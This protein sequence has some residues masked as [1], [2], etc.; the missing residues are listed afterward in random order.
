MGDM[1]L[2]DLT[3]STPT[4]FIKE[5]EMPLP[6]AAPLLTLPALQ[7]PTP[8]PAGGKAPPQRKSA[9]RG[10]PSVAAGTA[11][12]A[13]PYTPSTRSAAKAPSGPAAA[14]IA[15]VG[16]AATSATASA[17][18]PAPVVVNARALPDGGYSLQP[19]TGMAGQSPLPR[20]PAPHLDDSRASQAWQP[21]PQLQVLG[22]PSAGIG[23]DS[24]SQV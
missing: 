21:Q 15:D 23:S 3:K 12:T 14:S 7:R 11:G 8:K 24:G 9:S 19:S 4:M 13:M 20:S 5:E 2:S 22:Q 16:A 1:S 17:T 6:A 18:S 10:G